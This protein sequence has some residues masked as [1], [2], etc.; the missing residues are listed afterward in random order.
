MIDIEK[1]TVLPLK[2]LAVRLAVPLSYA[3]LYRYV[4]NGVRNRNTGSTIKL[5]SIWIAGR[6]VSSVEAFTRFVNK[7]NAQPEEIR[8]SQ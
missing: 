3:T 8:M 4:T 2:A 6:R 1:E 5:E 7:Q